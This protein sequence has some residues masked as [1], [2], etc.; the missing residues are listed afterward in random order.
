MPSKI[1][2]AL[3]LALA[4]LSAAAQDFKF[5]DIGYPST[6]VVT[7]E[8]NVDNSHEIRFIVDLNDD[9]IASFHV[10]SSLTGEQ[11]YG[12]AKARYTTDFVTFSTQLGLWQF[13]A[14]SGSFGWQ[15][16]RNISSNGAYYVF[17]LINEN[18]SSDTTFKYWFDYAVP[19]P[20][21]ETYALMLAGLGL[22]GTIARRRN[23]RGT[24]G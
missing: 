14:N 19:V 7:K 12:Q 22:L 5:I 8:T 23:P 16:P 2:A 18:F 3:L 13:S 4:S 9:S 20:E 15:A 10:D 6:I 21:P 1:V 11:H 24:A 17:S